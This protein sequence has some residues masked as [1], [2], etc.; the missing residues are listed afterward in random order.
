[1]ELKTPTVKERQKAWEAL[2]EKERTL[3]L[4]KGHD[5]TAGRAD[6]DAY[7][8][9]RI[10]A[11]LLK[12]VPVTAFSVALVYAL[13]HVLSIITFAKSGK[14]E[15]GEALEGRFMDIRNYMF[16]L[17]EL[18][19]DHIN[20]FDEPVPVFGGTL[21]CS[22]MEQFPYELSVDGMFYADVKGNWHPISHFIGKE[23]DNP[24]PPTP[25]SGEAESLINENSTFCNPEN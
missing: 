6:I 7:S 13:K 9:F 16:I 1:M 2:T 14:Q 22:E 17:N 10:I 18:V 8:N 5:Y 19:P 12:G 11:D 4:N 3:L 24:T 20:S 25:Q 21:P 15:S 23:D